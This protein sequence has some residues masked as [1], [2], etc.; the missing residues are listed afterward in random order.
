MEIEEWAKRIQ[1]EARNARFF[2]QIAIKYQR[3]LKRS[4]I[5]LS[6]PMLKVESVSN[7]QMNGELWQ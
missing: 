2:R 1:E 3:L 6:I 4:R 5:D 7:Y